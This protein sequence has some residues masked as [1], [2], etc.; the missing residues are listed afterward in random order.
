MDLPF[1]KTGTAQ[2]MLDKFAVKELVEYERFCRDNGLWAH[3]RRCFA[4]GSAVTVSWFQ[5]S[6]DD[7]VEQSSKMELR[8]P[9]RIQNTLVWLN[10]D[11]AVAVMMASI[12]PRKTWNGREYDLN[13]YVRLLYRAVRLNGGWKIL[14]MECIYERDA[15]LP[16]MPEGIPVPPGARGSYAA[17]TAVLGSEGYAIAD[18]LPGDDIPGQAAAK[19]SGAASWLGREA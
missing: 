4:P 9:H 19:L 6:G 14:S 13:S 18:D 10:G 1:L 7:F 8:A 2:E 5:G 15:L 11:R 3:M 12:Q 16:V 17:L